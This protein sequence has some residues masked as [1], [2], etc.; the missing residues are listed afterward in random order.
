MGTEQKGGYDHS[1][2]KY[3]SRKQ[4]KKYM[5]S[6]KDK[7]FDYQYTVYVFHPVKAKNNILKSYKSKA[8][9]LSKTQL[10]NNYK[11]WEVFDKNMLMA[12]L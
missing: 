5:E 2:E 8:L 9:W 10:K 6:L 4:I 7:P 1:N 3:Q 12:F 11:N